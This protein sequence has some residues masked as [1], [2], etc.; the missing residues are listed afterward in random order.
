MQS[1]AQP[2]SPAHVD[3]RTTDPSYTV[4]GWG[5]DVQRPAVEFSELANADR[6]GFTV[7]GSGT[8]TV[9]TPVWYRPGQAL[10]AV[11]TD[12]QR[13]WTEQVH[14]GPDGRLSLRMDLGAGNPFQEYTAAARVHALSTATDKG[15]GYSLDRA[16][17]D[18]TLVSAVSVRLQPPS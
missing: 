3:Y 13:T 6:D 7:A 2:S 1:F 15:L 16:L 4:F 18:G 14:A 17:G 12:E 5:V 9:T 8:A 10:A 11:V